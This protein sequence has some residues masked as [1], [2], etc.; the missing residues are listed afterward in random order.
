MGSLLEGQII[1]KRVKVLVYAYVCD[2]DVYIVYTGI[3]RGRVAKVS[4][5]SL[6]RMTLLHISL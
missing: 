2:H 3:G 6:D 4:M 1:I 5:R